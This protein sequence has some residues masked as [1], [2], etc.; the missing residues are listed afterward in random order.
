MP[1]FFA[2]DAC[3]WHFRCCLLSR[4]V[5]HTPVVLHVRAQM[6][7]SRPACH[8]HALHFPYARIDL[9]VSLLQS[10]LQTRYRLTVML[11]CLPFVSSATSFPVLCIPLFIRPRFTRHRFCVLPIKNNIVSAYSLVKFIAPRARLPLRACTRTHTNT[12]TYKQTHTSK[13]PLRLD[14]LLN[15]DVLQTSCYTSMHVRLRAG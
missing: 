13:T 9:G 4:G 6:V 15:S 10:H 2:S 8:R 3:D 11:L 14:L 1:C 12:R 5:S 7:A